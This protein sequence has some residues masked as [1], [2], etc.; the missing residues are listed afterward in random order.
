MRRSASYDT[1]PKL[2]YDPTLK[3][4]KYTGAGQRF[5]A[6]DGE[7]LSADG[8]IVRDTDPLGER[9]IGVNPPHDKWLVVAPGK[10]HDGITSFYADWA[11]GLIVK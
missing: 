11:I 1:A 4:L 9:N 2:S 6:S 3:A 10:P 5:I 7:W 8:T